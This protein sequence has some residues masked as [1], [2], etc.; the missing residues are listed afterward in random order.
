[1]SR[2]RL[3][4]IKSFLHVADSQSLS[5]SRMMAEVEPL[6]GFLN[7]KIQQFGIAHQDL[8]IDKSMVPYFGRHSC[9][10]FIRAKPIRFGYK[11]WVLASATGVPY[12]IEIYQ[13]RTNHG[14]NEPFVHVLSK[15]FLTTSF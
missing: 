15:F 7:E 3:L 12:K 14:S 6:Y 4:E 8:S 10:Q 2:N 5:E 1:M 9:K 11:L 13:G